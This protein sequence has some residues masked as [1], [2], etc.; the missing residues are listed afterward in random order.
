M[1]MANDL[2]KL[3]KEV[4]TN[5]QSE[6]SLQQNESYRVYQEMINDAPDDQL[7]ATYDRKY[8]GELMVL[9]GK[10]DSERYT[11]SQKAI[12]ETM[13]DS[14]TTVISKLGD[15]E[16]QERTYALAKR[17]QKID[18]LRKA[19]S[20]P[21]RPDI[22]T[23]KKIMDEMYKKS[24]HYQMSVFSAEEMRDWAISKVDKDKLEFIAETLGEKKDG[25]VHYSPEKAQKFLGEKIEEMKDKD[26]EGYFMDLARSYTAKKGRK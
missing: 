19:I 11:T 2:E 7:R 21:E 17:D 8:G 3:V 24:L 23:I 12:L 22:G 9:Q 16:I 20:N 10:V 26:K 13:A 5:F 4:Q 14:Y 15:G 18:T 25:K 6:R 1:I